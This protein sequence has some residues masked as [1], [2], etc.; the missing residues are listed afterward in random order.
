[1]TLF[2]VIRLQPVHP[3]ARSALRL[4]DRHCQPAQPEQRRGLRPCRAPT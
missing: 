1:L 4:L 2:I 3:A